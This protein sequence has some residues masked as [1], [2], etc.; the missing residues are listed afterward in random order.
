VWLIWSKKWKRWHR[1]S[2]S[3]GACG[4]TD[5]ISQAGLFPRAKAAGYNDGWDNTV[6][7]VS[8]KID[9]FN[10]EIARMEG[11]LAE[12]RRALALAAGASHDH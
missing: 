3:G 5:D 6:F 11:Q 7:H 2:D 10:R 4:Y 1:R 12:F 8:E 9:A